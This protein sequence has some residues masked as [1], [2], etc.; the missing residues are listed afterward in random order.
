MLEPRKNFLC[1]FSF[2][3]K[4]FAFLLLF[5]FFPQFLSAVAANCLKKKKKKREKRGRGK[6][7]EEKKSKN[8]I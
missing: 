2:D 3:E 6:K 7:Q 5:K 4:N 1:T 8:K